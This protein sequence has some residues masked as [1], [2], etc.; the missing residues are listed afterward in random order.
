MA[1]VAACPCCVGRRNGPLPHSKSHAAAEAAFARVI[2]REIDTRNHPCQTYCATVQ[3]LNQQVCDGRVR[4]QAAAY[5]ASRPS[6]I[7]ERC[8]LSYGFLRLLLRQD[9]HEDGCACVDVVLAWGT[10][11]TLVT[12][13]GNQRGTT[14]F[15]LVQGERWRQAL[16][17]YGGMPWPSFHTMDF[18]GE[19]NPRISVARIHEYFGNHRMPIDMLWLE[20]LQRQWFRWHNRI[21]RRLWVAVVGP[22]ATLL[23]T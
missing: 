11:P 2:A 15:G 9:R 3:Q 22:H 13:V 21:G 14:A 6:P 16:V 18:V 8:S 7:F 1:T 20:A 12:V 4:K 5:F 23:L 10:C 17:A 19:A